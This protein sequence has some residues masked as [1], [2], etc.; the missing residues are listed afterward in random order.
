MRP[1]NSTVMGY[2]PSW[3]SVIFLT[4]GRHSARISA[5]STTRVTIRLPSRLTQAMDIRARLLDVPVNSEYVSAVN[6]YLEEDLRM[7]DLT[8]PAAELDPDLEHSDV[9]AAQAAPL[10]VGWGTVNGRFDSLTLQGRVVSLE[11]EWFRSQEAFDRNCARIA[12]LAP[13]LA[14]GMEAQWNGEVGAEVRRRTYGW[15]GPPGGK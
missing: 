13:L 2:L 4:P 15:P 11:R 10:F 1:L 6:A 12:E 7:I 9:R 8:I 14:A 3:M 5:M